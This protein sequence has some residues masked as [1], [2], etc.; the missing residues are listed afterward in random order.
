MEIQLQWKRSNKKP[1][2]K[3]AKR[4]GVVIIQTNTDLSTIKKQKR[5]WQAKEPTCI[6][7]RGETIYLN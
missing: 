3:N 4:K 1:V 6:V 2:V 7:R 5:N